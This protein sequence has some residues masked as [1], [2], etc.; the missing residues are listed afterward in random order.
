[1][2]SYVPENGLDLEGTF[3]PGITK[4]GESFMKEN[5]NVVEKLVAKM[6]YEKAKKDVNSTCILWFYQ[7]KLPDSLKKLKVEK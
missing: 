3:V 6:A 1:M 7:P 4:K 5:K 2:L